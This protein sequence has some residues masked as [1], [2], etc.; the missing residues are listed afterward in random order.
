MFLIRKCYCKSIRTSFYGLLALM[1]VTSSVSAQ[2][3]TD[4]VQQAQ[5]YLNSITTLTADFQQ[6][7]PDGSYAN[8]ELFL[9]RPGKMRWNYRKPSAIEM[10]FNGDD[11]TYY[12]PEMDE[13][14]YLSLDD[15]V[16]AI[17]AQPNIKL[18]GEAIELLGS[19]DEGG[20]LRIHTRP[21]QNPDNG[22]LSFVFRTQPIEL[23]Q[24]LAQN[25]AG[26]VTI[27]TLDNIR[28]GETLEDKLFR[29]IRPENRR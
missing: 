18:G 4:S 12:D 10:V 11:L 8:G 15:T 16:A 27:I 21:R 25:A 13:V 28:M 26:D 14:S 23:Y 24:L 9:K 22:A 6:I 1:L 29:F 17:I 19:E 20:L 2:A 3:Q 5:A 7:A